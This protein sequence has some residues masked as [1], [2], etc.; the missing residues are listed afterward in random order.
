MRQRTRPTVHLPSWALVVGAGVLGLTFWNSPLLYPLKLLSVILHEAGHTLA[1]YL[2]GGT[3]ERISIDAR[4]GGVTHSQYPASLWREVVIASA[5][6]LGSAFFGALALRLAAAPE[7]ARWV[8]GTLGAALLVLAVLFLR[9]AFS[10]GFAVLAAGALLAG[11]RWLPGFLVHPVAVFI[12][13]FV[14]L[15]ALFDL[16]ADL[17]TLPWESGPLG[18]TDAD[19]LADRLPVPALVWSLVWTL[20]AAVLVLWALKG[21]FR[22][23]S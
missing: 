13:A 4:Q 5:G 10:L 19:L 22:P 2:V 23:R 16:R 6:Y 18:R 9:D 17:W 21:T 11:A 7:R 20:L 3:V 1:T 14:C 8:L 15:Y 12:A